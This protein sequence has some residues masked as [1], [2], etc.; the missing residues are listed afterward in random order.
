MM[1][2]L[3]LNGEEMEKTN[4]KQQRRHRAETSPVGAIDN[5]E[6]RCTKPEQQ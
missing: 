5:V 2:L 6:R 1:L 3:K 4:E